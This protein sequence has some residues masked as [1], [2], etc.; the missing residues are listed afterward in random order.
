MLRKRT[1]DEAFWRGLRAYYLDHQHGNA[2]TADFRRAMEAASGQNLEAFFTQWLTRSDLPKITGTWWYD[3]DHQQ[4]TVDLQQTQPGA[5]FELPLTLGLGER[6]E[7]VILTKKQHQV[8]FA[9][10]SAPAYI[11]LDPNT[12][13]LLNAPGRLEPR[14][15]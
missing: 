1:G 10:A 13:A 6:L 5:P 4:I 12:E 3:S 15:R 8:V 2:T 11:E 7:T 9:A 14:I